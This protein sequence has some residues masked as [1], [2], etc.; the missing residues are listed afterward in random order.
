MLVHL[1]SN[2]I[3]NTRTHTHTYTHN[4]PLSNTTHTHT[5]TY[6]RTRAQTHITHTHTHTQTHT[7]IHQLL[8]TRMEDYRRIAAERYANKTLE[9]QQVPSL[10]V[11]PLFTI[12]PT[13]FFTKGYR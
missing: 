13:S 8:S 9:A 4:H 11:N 1:I 10:L 12:L 7:L 3:F 5:H 2:E 6:T